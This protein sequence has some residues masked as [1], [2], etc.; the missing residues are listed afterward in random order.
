MLRLA[1]TSALL[2]LACPLVLGADLERRLVIAAKRGDMAKLHSLLG[3]VGQAPSERMLL[4]LMKLG[5]ETPSQQIFLGIQKV[6]AR[7]RGTE[8]LTTFNRVLAKKK[9]FRYRTLA[10]MALGDIP[11]VETINLLVPFLKDKDERIKLQVA[12]ALGKKSHRDSIEGLI[13]VLEEADKVPGEFSLTIRQALYRLT[14]MNLAT[15]E[16][17]EKWWKSVRGQWET[18]PIDSGRGRTAPGFVKPPGSFP[19]FFGVEIYSLKV[20][21][22]IDVSGSMTELA[23]HHNISRVQLV[24][25]ELVRLIRELRP[26]TR[27]AIIAFNDEIMPHAKSLVLSTPRNKARAIRFV[28]RLTPNGFT[29]THEALEKAF[30]YQNAN[31]I[32]LLSDGCPCKRGHPAMPTKPILQWVSRVNRFRQVTIHSIGFPQAF[33][34]FLRTLALDNGGTY[35]HAG[36][37]QDTWGPDK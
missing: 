34:P 36:L 12:K 13:S 9:D 10:V 18:G 1:R 3:E 15:A 22:V 19:R 28:Q 29:W 20:L 23:K 5:V 30:S 8:A 7:I 35:R 17:W 14:A 27:F 4:L 24:K 25:N 2:L 33:V 11:A 31:T 37:P 16:D 21:F 32:V 26:E 6:F